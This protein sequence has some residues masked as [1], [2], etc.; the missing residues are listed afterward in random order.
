MRTE[1]AATIGAPEVRRP[2]SP[3]DR[4]RSRTPQRRREEAACRID[5]A[6][7]GDGPDKLAMTENRPR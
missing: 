7:E 1:S 3:P 5:A 4:W 6:G 2:K